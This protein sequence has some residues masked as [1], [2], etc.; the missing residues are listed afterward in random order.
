MLLQSAE[1]VVDSVSFTSVRVKGRLDEPQPTCH[2]CTH[3]V[4]IAPGP[5][6][7]RR[8]TRLADLD[9][10][11][12][13]AG[14][15]IAGLN[16]AL[17]AAEGG[18]RVVVCE[19]SALIGGTSAYS[20]AMVWVPMS[21]QAREAGVKDSAEAALAYL[22]AAGGPFFRE[23]HAR[24]YLATAP[25]A[26]EFLETHS[27][28]RY[29]LSVG[30]VDYLSDLPGA[31]AGIRAL[32]PLPFDGRRLGRRFQ[33]LRPPLATT[34]VLGGMSVAAEDLPHLLRV[35]RSL[36]A[37]WHAA[38]LVAAHAADRLAG[39][40]RGTRLT[41][42]NG[43]LAALLLAL[44]GRGVPVLTAT[45]L[46]RLSRRGGRVAE[47]VI[48]A[49][50]AERRVAVAR[51][52]LL[53]AG[54]FSRAPALLGRFAPH[55]AAGR[56]HHSLAT[57]TARGE[58]AAIAGELGARL[59]SRMQHPLAWAPVSLVPQR[60]GGV[61]GY[62]HFIDRQKPGMICVDRRGRRFANEAQSYHLFVPE[63]LHA[64]RDDPTDEVF[65]IAD[66]RA[67]RRHGLGVAPPAPGRLG[68]HLA[69]GYLVRSAT[70]AGLAAALGIAPAGLERTV[71]AFNAAARRGEDP[72][73]GRGTTAYDRA[74]G[75]PAHRPNPCLG[76]L[77]TPPF[78]AVRL[79][80]GDLGSF[81]G[82]EADEAGRVLDAEWQLIP[83]LYA[84]GSDMASP[85]GG[86][87][88]GAGTA[89]GAAITFGYLAAR[90][91]ACAAPAAAPALTA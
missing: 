31:S 15:G 69:S 51:G 85:M 44:D 10:D 73:F 62:P 36:P 89:V 49:D 54:G 37:T 32:S 59:R 25:A 82:L 17:V 88:P 40:G 1:H 67:Q 52:V 18:L 81:A 47:A 6:A 66:S 39:Y 4:G 53:A 63:M 21:R 12:L 90:D 20:E 45:P 26:L 55:V 16:A 56:P 29:S 74:N 84:A 83:G 72:E 58:T 11:F 7:G 8:G 46:R 43:V 71:A 2:L 75:D 34:Q 13:V 42:G 64:T 70:L 76:P 57:E 68:P 35:G 80:P 61:V 19:A 87:Y 22:A 24:A 78:Y 3:S 79:L 27:A 77:E 28:V 65:L 91:A 60:G 5:A 50:G 86:A 48:G 9:C 30:S 38:R 41:G 23:A 33:D 14:A